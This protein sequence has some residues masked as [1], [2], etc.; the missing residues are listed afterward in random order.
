M[1]ERALSRV[2]HHLVQRRLS[3]AARQVRRERL[4]YLVP[5]KL[6]QVERA[7]RAAQRAG[8]P[9]DF[10]ECG[11]ALGGSAVL[12]ARG[13]SAQGRCFDG[14]DV[15]GMIPPPTDKDP[16]EVHERYQTIVSGQ[17]R[18]IEGD[19][20]YGY[21]PDL[22]EHVARTLDRFGAPVGP[23]VRLHKGLFDETLHPSGP[24]ALAHVDCDWYE[25][26]KLCLERIYPHLAVGGRL[27]VDDYYDWGGARDAT[28]ELLGAHGD[29]TVETRRA[30][31][32]VHRG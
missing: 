11:V 26:V 30:H 18:G 24:V 16:P 19:K 6:L 12:L 17:S 4:T 3:S 13:A 21:R 5:V 22:Y 27:I 23:R 9:G 8:V 20:Y 29:L 10:L 28:N 2:H 7:I 32:I 25:P 1:I 14:Y 31:L 15:F